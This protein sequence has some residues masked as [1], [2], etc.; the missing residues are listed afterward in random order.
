MTWNRQE[1]HKGIAFWKEEEAILLQEEE[2]EEE[3]EARKTS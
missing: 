1:N 2:E 3:E